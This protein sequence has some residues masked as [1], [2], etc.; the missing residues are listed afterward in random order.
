MG[1][2][3]HGAVYIR[4]LAG[5]SVRVEMNIIYNI[6]HKKGRVRS[7]VK[8]KIKKSDTSN[9][10]INNNIDKKNYGEN[11]ENRSSGREG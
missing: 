4:L 6:L 10:R 9:R 8:K 7:N 11:T 5:G 1:C 2:T 3:R